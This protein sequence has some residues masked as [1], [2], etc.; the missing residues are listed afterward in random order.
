MQP[1]LNMAIKAS[2]DSSKCRFVVDQ[3]GVVR[4]K[5]TN[6]WVTSYNP[7]IAFCIRSNHD[8]IWILSS[9]KALAYVYYLTS[10]ATKADI[11]PRD[12]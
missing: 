12:C 2:A 9:S 11:S 6:G 10:Y 3:F 8:I 5:R 7:A 1:V 4:V